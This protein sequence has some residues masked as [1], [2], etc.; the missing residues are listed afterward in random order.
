MELFI[1]KLLISLQTINN[2]KSVNQLFSQSALKAQL[3]L[4][5]GR[6]KRH[7]G[8]YYRVWFRQA[9]SP[10]QLLISIAVN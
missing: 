4:A 3:I 10:A 8:I 1:I 9:E 6:A 5:R 7:P 2:W